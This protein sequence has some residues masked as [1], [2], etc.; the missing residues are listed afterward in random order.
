MDRAILNRNPCLNGY[1]YE[2]EKLGSLR[3]SV[4]FETEREVDR[5][6]RA[7]SNEILRF[8]DDC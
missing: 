7:L 8:F 4:C 3:F 5:E 1:E 2:N 6:C